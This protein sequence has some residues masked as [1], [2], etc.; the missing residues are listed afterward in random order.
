SLLLPTLPRSTLFPYTTLFRSV[1]NWSNLYAEVLGIV[2]QPQTLYTRNGPQ[3]TLQPLGTQAFDKSIIPFYNV[4]FSDTWRM[5]PTFTLTY[6]LGYT[7]EMPPYEIEGKQ[8]MLV[9]AAANPIVTEDYLAQRKTAALAG[10]V[11]NPTLGF[12]TVRN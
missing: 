5:R 4:Y 1:S 3:L 12:A 8:V 6:G 11:Y 7:V 9:D 2:N 10:Q